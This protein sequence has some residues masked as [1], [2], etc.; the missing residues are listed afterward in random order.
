MP[1]QPPLYQLLPDNIQKIY[2][3]D[4]GQWVALKNEATDAMD[5]L[6]AEVQYLLKNSEDAPVLLITSSIWATEPGTALQWCT[7][8]FSKFVFSTIRSFV[9]QIFVLWIHAKNAR[10]TLVAEVPVT[11]LMRRGRR[12]C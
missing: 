10:S 3:G 4:G 2:G 9:V 11:R 1:T 7:L 12:H 6:S 5:A 8:L